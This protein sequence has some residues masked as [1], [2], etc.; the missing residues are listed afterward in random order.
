MLAKNRHHVVPVPPE[1]IVRQYFRS[2]R[3]DS[4]RIQTE[5]LF[6]TPVEITVYMRSTT[7]PSYQSGRLRFAAGCVR[8]MTVV[9]LE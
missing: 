5:Y 2:L 4:P 1:C 6:T 7:L 3:T 9:S 8:R